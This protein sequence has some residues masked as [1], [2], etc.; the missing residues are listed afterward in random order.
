MGVLREADRHLGRAFDYVR[1]QPDL[2]DNTIIL[3]CSDN[4]HEPGMGS[5]GEL[6]GA[7]GQLYEG[8]IRSP[9]IVWWPGGMAAAAA[10]TVNDKTVVTGMDLP[11]SLLALAGVGA[12]G[13]DGRA[14]TSA[15]VPA[16]DGLDM[17]EALAGR[18][19]PER[20]QPV[21][22]VRPPDRPGPKGNLPD[23]AIRDGR[24][25][26]LVSRRGTN[27]ELFDVP[28]DPGETKNLAAEQ[29]EVVE[30]L[31]RAV[32]AWDEAVGR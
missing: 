4:G 13:G 16:F 23:L 25:K 30:R 24:W 22:W 5:G 26:L 3:L 14:G 6:R 29:P 17:S 12:P 11:P 18:G 31:T 2:K 28:A 7:K 27:A 1:T 19:A 10:G 15:A 8:G 9:L 32:I 20:G 21:M